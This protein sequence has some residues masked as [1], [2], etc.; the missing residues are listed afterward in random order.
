MPLR[1]KNP[2]KNTKV[3]EVNTMTDIKI[4]L[5]EPKQT[6]ITEPGRL[7]AA[8]ARSVGNQRDH[9]EDSLF[10]MTS[11]LAN[12]EIYRPFGLYIVA[13]GMGGHRH[14]EIAS[15]KAV[16]I[17]S[18]YV[19]EHL[20]TPIFDIS[21]HS[22]EEETPEEI[23]RAAVKRAHE[24]ILQEVE[25]GGT[26]LTAVLIINDTV[27]IAH[28]GDSRAYYISV[29]GEAKVLTRDH[30][31]VNKLIE[32][33]QL[34]PQ[35]AAVHPQRNVLLRAIGQTDPFEVDII[36]PEFP[37]QGHILICSDGL[38][39]VVSSEEISKITT[40]SCHPEEACNKL[41]NAANVAGG[42]DNITAVLL[43]F[44]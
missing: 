10:M 37:K 23:L 27:T 29:S 2:F 19:V 42:P 25:G 3:Q 43:Q 1:W 36:N 41:V 17:V 35:E 39:G 20:F 15:G 9:N 34:T 18:N 7:V 5:G 33:G 32:L 38:W 11:T 16:A 8:C 6:G 40:S 24:V 22:L 12:D 26:T 28:V 13:D 31:L 30:S 14:G 44:S 4:Q 21:P